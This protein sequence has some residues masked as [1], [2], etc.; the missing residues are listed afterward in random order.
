M[1]LVRAVK[2]E[3]NTVFSLQT[4]TELFYL[5]FEDNLLHEVE[6]DGFDEFGQTKWKR[7]G[8]AYT[9]DQINELTSR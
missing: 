9:P 8:V 2:L 4:N 7:N 1:V 5:E 6:E 3:N